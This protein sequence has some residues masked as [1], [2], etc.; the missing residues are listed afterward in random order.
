MHL[1]FG[2]QSSVSSCFHSK[3][4]VKG[5]S[6]NQNIVSKVDRQTSLP[7]SRRGYTAILGQTQAALALHLYL[8]VPRTSLTRNVHAIVTATPFPRRRTST[9]LTHGPRHV[10]DRGACHVRHHSIRKSPHHVLSLLHLQ[11]LLRLTH[12]L[13]I[14]LNCL[15]AHHRG[16]LVLRIESRLSICSRIRCC[17]ASV[18]STHGGIESS[19]I[20]L[21]CLSLVVLLGGHHLLC[22]KLLRFVAR[23]IGVLCP[24]LGSQ[25]LND[26]YWSAGKRLAAHICNIRSR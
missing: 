10:H 18:G 8:S 9:M 4:L 23:E 1:L 11:C 22:C 24:D 26:G 14:H 20:T 6:V 15:V 16:R 2:S 13:I 3:S 5:Q 17:L 12:S 19:L 21:L 7:S 25:L